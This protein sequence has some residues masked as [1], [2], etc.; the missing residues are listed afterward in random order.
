MT[1]KLM[2][3]LKNE[4]SSKVKKEFNVENIMM[5]P[6]L[7]KVILSSGAGKMFKNSQ[8]MDR[9]AKAMSYIAAQ[10]AVL[11]SARKSIA[12]FDVR[13]GMKIGAKV[14]L[15]K[16]KMWDFLERL[17]LLTLPRMRDFKGFDT[18]SFN[19]RTFNFGIK[20]VALAFF[21]LPDLMNVYDFTFGMNI[22]F[23]FSKAD[24]NLQ[25]KVLE[26]LGFPFKK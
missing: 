21:E 22:T 3:E 14:T 4:V 26:E 2:K 16:E 9:L 8:E 13:E 23:V 12:G 15:R 18:N 25:K 24:K 17:K 5:I 10:K 6:R 7:E 19:D 11:T 1:Y 20:D